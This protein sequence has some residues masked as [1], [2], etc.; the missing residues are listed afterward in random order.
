MFVHF[1]ALSE[2]PVQRTEAEQRHQQQTA[3]EQN[4]PHDGDDRTVGIKGVGNTCNC[5]ANYEEH[6]AEW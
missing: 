4:Q 6:N 5:N 2:F 1:F 3:G